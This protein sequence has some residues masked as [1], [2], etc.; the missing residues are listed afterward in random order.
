[1]KQFGTFSKL[2]ALSLALA[3]AFFVSSAQA[4]TSAGTQPGQAKVTKIT[5]T[6]TFKGGGQSGELKVG[7]ILGAGATIST[8]V[9]ATVELDLGV[10]GKSLTIKPDSTVAIDKLDFSNT[11]EGT[12]INTRLNLTK[13][14]LSGNVKKLARESKYEVQTAKGVAGVRGTSYSILSSGV[15]HVWTGS[16][17]V[18]Y[19]LDDGTQTDPIEVVAGQTMYPPTPPSRVPTLGPPTGFED[20]TVVEVPEAGARPGFPTYIYISPTTGIVRVVP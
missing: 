11:C 7:Q 8:G 15:I 4:A 3:A 1:M 19:T 14:G 2:A 13:G 12:V 10:N 5:G 9:A 6:A 16:M 17:M 18:V 20:P